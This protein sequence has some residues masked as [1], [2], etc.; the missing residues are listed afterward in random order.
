MEPVKHPVGSPVLFI[1]SVQTPLQKSSNQS[2]Y[3]SRKKEKHRCGWIIKKSKETLIQKINH[4]LSL[5]SD[6]TKIPV[7]LYL[8]DR[9]IEGII[10]NLSGEL[11]T[12]VD[13]D[14]NT[15]YIPLV[16]LVDV[17]LL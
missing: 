8:K 16:D 3:D 13:R 4:I 9:T 1:H 5:Q 6:T 15:I 14:E 2:I 10:T 12:I 7:F 11:I 17:L